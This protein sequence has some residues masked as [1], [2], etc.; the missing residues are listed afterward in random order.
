[1]HYPSCLRFALFLACLA[2]APPTR[3]DVFDY[4]VNPVLARVTGAEGTQE[5][6]ELPK[7]LLDQHDRVLRNLPGTF[8]VVKTNQGRNAKLLVRLARQRTDDGQ[9]VPMLLVQRFVT[10][11]EG[12]E[13]TIQA[14]GKDLCLYPGFRLSLDLGQVVPE[15][16]GGDLRFVAEGDKLSV[17]PLGKAKLF[18]VTKE[19]PDVV[20]KKG[21]KPVVGATF[22]PGYFNGTYKL[23]DDGRRSGTL[24]LKVDDDGAISGSYYSDKDGRKYEVHGRVGT[25]KHAIQFTVKFPQSEQSFQGWLFTGD[26]EI[27]TGSS[28]LAERE[29]GFYAR[30]VEE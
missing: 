8:L 16:L 15:V 1:M 26:G 10:Y 7:R 19:L 17:Q 27:L 4:Y 2:L 11:K 28:R 9:S 12:E 14:D 25:P 21:P 20:A 13:R 6:K 5:V 18:L 3:A 30:R 23:Y 29:A 22:E 24:T